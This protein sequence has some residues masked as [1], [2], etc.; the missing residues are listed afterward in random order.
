[1]D[2]QNIAFLLI[3]RGMLCILQHHH[4]ANDVL[5]SRN[6]LLAHPFRALVRLLQRLRCARSLLLLGLWLSASKWSQFQLQFDY[7]NGKSYKNYSIDFILPADMLKTTP[8]RITIRKKIFIIGFGWW[9]R[10]LC[11]FAVPGGL[12]LYMVFIIETPG[13]TNS[14]K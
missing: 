4:H 3:I 6:N 13:I 5:F 7:F 8:R 14:Q 1:M 2:F 9:L 11:N 10:G 12:Y